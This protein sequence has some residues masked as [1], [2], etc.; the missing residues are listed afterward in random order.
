MSHTTPHAIKKM[1]G[2][3]EPQKV[4]FSEMNFISKLV[5]F[6]TFERLVDDC[7]FVDYYSQ[8]SISGFKCSMFHANYLIFPAV[9]H[10]KNIRITE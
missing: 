4:E 8:S 5:F 1:S 2:S 7:W 3:C 6:K 10:F 9:T